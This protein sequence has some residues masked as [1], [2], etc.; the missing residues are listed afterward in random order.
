MAANL[1]AER[2]TLL[3][4]LQELCA[5]F[6]YYAQKTLTFQYEGQDGAAQMAQIMEALRRPAEAFGPGV[7]TGAGKTDYLRDE[8]GLPQSDVIEFR[9][10]NGQKFIVR[11][12]G[13]EPKLKAYLFSRGATQ[14][15][16]ERSLEELEP[17]VRAL[18]G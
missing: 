12:S 9:L 10:A 6:G 7:M 17:V 1:K 4:R 8:T 15:E 13:T 18:C 2:K 3:D 16:A 11:P 14:E 5:E